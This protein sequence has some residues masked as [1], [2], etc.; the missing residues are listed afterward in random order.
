MSF[1]STVSTVYPLSRLVKTIVE[2]KETHM[3]ELLKIMGLRDWV[4]QLSWFLTSFILFFWIALS[5]TLITTFSFLHTSNKMLIFLFFFLFAMSE[6]SLS[7]LVAV[8]FT[9]SKLAAVVGPFVLFAALL[10]RFIFLSTNSNEN[11][12]SKLLASILSP[13]AFSFGADIIANYESADLG[14][15]YSNM[16]EGMYSFADSLL[17]MF[18]DAFLYGIMAWYIDQV[19]PTEFGTQKHPLFLFR[20]SYWCNNNASEAN[21]FDPA[22]EMTEIESGATDEHIESLPIEQYGLVRVQLSGL[23]KRYA[24]GKMAVNGISMG[25][26]EGQITCLLGHNGAGKSS[27]VSMLTGLTTPTAGECLVWG[28]CLSRDL[29]SIRKITGIW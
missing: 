19:M 9:N 12:N 13:S 17:F 25:L 29:K 2:E 3:K 22:P 10:P 21:K 28:H 5:T 11:R 18:I 23:K 14:V 15:Q 27:L 20:K 6:I 7:F 4:H 16:H 26:L 24:D 1:A 8:F